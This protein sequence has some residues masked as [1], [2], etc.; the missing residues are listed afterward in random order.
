MRKLLVSLIVAASLA[1]PS[2]GLVT[3]TS[4][5]A[6]AKVAAPAAMTAVGKV[7]A[8]STKYCTVTLANEGVFVFGKGC[9]LSK[10]KVGDWVTITWTKSGNWRHATKI[11]ES[12][13]MSMADMMKA[14]MHG[15]MMH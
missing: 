1:V 6:A 15:M 9:K 3:A 14:D 13:A 5:V 8:V 11:V 12:K 7:V 2:A 10:I 4:A